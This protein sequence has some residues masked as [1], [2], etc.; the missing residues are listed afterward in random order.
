[1]QH[2][3]KF[4]RDRDDGGWSIYLLGRDDA[5]GH[6]RQASNGRWSGTMVLDGQHGR[7]IYDDQQTVVDQF[8]YWAAVGIPSTSEMQAQSLAQARAWVANL[9]DLNEKDNR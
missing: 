5:I 6:I 3:L 1:M 8:E 4:E 9:A 2:Q 7:F